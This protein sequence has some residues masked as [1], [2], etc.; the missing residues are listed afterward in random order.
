[1]NMDVMLV[2]L[3]QPLHNIVSERRKQ[4]STWIPLLQIDLYLFDNNTTKVQYVES[5]RRSRFPFGP[6][7]NSC[8]RTTRDPT[9]DET[10]VSAAGNSTTGATMD[11][12]T[13]DAMGN[14]SPARGGIAFCLQ[15]KTKDPKKPKDFLTGLHIWEYLVPIFKNPSDRHKAFM[16]W[17]AVEY[18]HYV[19]KG[20]CRPRLSF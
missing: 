4:E 15:K 12:V 3:M 10:G 20:A 5:K 18:I 6:K 17:F 16:L 9:A 8:K 11:D 2:P 7:H 13:T 14:S 19:S 1:M